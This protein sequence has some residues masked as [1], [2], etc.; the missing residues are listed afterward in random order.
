MNLPAHLAALEAWGLIHPVM[1]GAE[2]EYRFRHAM[3]HEAAY[4]TLLRQ[5]RRELHLA[6]GEVLAAGSGPASEEMAPLLGFHFNE[7]GDMERARHYFAQAGANAA[8]KY[9]HHEAL[10]YYTQAIRAT[11]QPPAALFQAR[12]QVYE[13][14]GEFEAARQDF[15]HSAE[16]ARAAGDLAAEWQALLRLGLLWAGRDYDRSGKYC[17]MAFELAEKIGQPALIARSYNRLGNWHLN[18]E[19]PREA[20]RCHGQALVIFQA[21]RDEAG[22]A[23]TLDLLGMSSMLG[24]D[25]AR[26]VQYYQQAID[27]NRRLGDRLA[28]AHVLGS[29]LL[30][31]N[32]G[33]QTQTLRASLLS[34]ADLSAQGQQAARMTH[35]IGYR[36]DEAFVNMILSN[37]G[38]GRGDY[39]LALDAGA[40][41]LEIATEIGHRQW[42]AGLRYTLGL[43][44]YDILALPQAIELLKSGLE[45]SREIRSQHWM[46]C[47]IGM[48]AVAYV[49]S[50]MLGEAAAVLETGT[51]VRQPPE[52]LGERL[53]TFGRAC[54][55][56]ARGDL[57]QALQLADILIA[58]AQS[59]APADAYE[60]VPLLL[61]LRGGVQAD[62]GKLELAER[63]FRPA[64][65]AASA[66]G[67]RPLVWRLRKAL[68]QVL[69][70]Q[71]RPDEAAQEF[72]LARALVAELADGLPDAKLREH[73]RVQ[74]G[75]FASR[76]EELSRYDY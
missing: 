65:Q 51:D 4:S 70:Q 43:V 36:D 22:I 75:L 52:S 13:L 71:G 47:H 6:V 37:Y 63:D 3:V 56:R 30:A 21:L 16:V 73:F 46:R 27:L 40:A 44:D 33:Y 15:E 7:A 32:G 39:R 66:H 38:Q 9:A 1:S 23:E 26:G 69:E 42:M 62:L 28:L 41:G 12:G 19:Q 5:D 72:E 17:Q 76:I 11:A 2:V 50:Q 49:D 18:V 10:S 25:M 58:A 64:I 61:L 8:R 14:T 55:A 57:S 48:L 54:L 45:L 34:Q 67:E 31:A 60:P 74:S 53:V 68:A 59:V 24:G 35:E 20:A 29:Q